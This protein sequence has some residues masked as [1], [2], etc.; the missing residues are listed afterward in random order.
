M[1]AYLQQEN[2][3]YFC[4][5]RSTFC[6]PQLHTTNTYKASL[7]PNSFLL[8]VHRTIEQQSILA[9]MYNPTLIIASLLAATAVATPINKDVE[10][11]AT[12]TNFKLKTTV[13]NGKNDTGTEKGNL[14]VVSYHTG[15]GLGDATLDSNKTIGNVGHLNA[16][17]DALL[18]KIGEYQWPMELDYEPYAGT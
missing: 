13:I 2:A 11:R 18:F 17:N 3:L 14:W 12:P 5:S 1:L 16:S 7:Q 10:T 9:I 6:F 8:P 15:A 4:S